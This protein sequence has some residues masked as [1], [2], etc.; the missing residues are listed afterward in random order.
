VRTVFSRIRKKQET[1]KDRDTA[2]PVDGGRLPALYFR[3]RKC[4][5]DLKRAGAGMGFETG[6]AE[7]AYG[8]AIQPDRAVRRPRIHL[9]VEEA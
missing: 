8:S 7:A 6:S 9:H 3:K 5:I 2:F 4:F 1:P